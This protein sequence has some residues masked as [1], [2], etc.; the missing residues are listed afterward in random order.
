MNAK[1]RQGIELNYT[2][3]GAAAAAAVAIAR[4]AGDDV[5]IL[6]ATPGLLVR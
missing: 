5:M 6:C 1:A 2:N 3:I 4:Y